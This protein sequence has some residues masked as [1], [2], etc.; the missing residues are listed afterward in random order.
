MVL[1]FVL[2]AA[3]CV[4]CSTVTVSSKYDKAYPPPHYATYGWGNTHD[5]NPDTDK[6]VRSAIEEEFST[7]GY[8]LVR[9][10]EK[11]RFLINYDTEVE[12][13]LAKNDMEFAFTGTDESVVQYAQ[14]GPVVFPYNEGRLQIELIDPLEKRV[15]WRGEGTRI[16]A[17]DNLSDAQ[18][19]D[20]VKKVF[21]KFPVPAEP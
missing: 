13:R 18:I 21:E 4:G 20:A 15:V 19:D 7:R 12:Q 17:K 16:V 11:P 6:R 2:C 5:K 9:S 8:R 1:R 14:P 3:I 10:G